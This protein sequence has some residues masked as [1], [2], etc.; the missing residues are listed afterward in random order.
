M[1]RSVRLK[2]PT[3]PSPR[4]W[5][6]LKLTVSPCEETLWTWEQDIRG[7]LVDAGPTVWGRQLVAASC[8]QF[9]SDFIVL[10]FSFFL[11]ILV[12]FCIFSAP[13][14]FSGF[15]AP[16]PLFLL[17]FLFAFLVYSWIFSSCCG[18]ASF[19]FFILIFVLLLLHLYLVF[20]LFPLLLFFYSWYA[21]ISS[22][23]FF[24]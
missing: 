6:T 3:E 24:F 19:L 7:V 9:F 8:S 18:S 14:S 1:E 22:F 21:F 15:S 13:F 17:L 4:G 23:L 16:I 20:L 11:L 2:K 5:S 10:F 12:V